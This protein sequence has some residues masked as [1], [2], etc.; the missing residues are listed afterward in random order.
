MANKLKLSDEELAFINNTLASAPYHPHR[1]ATLYA[2]EVLE[3]Q[4]FD[5]LLGGLGMVNK[6]RSERSAEVQDA[7]SVKFGGEMLWNRF[8]EQIRDA[9]CG[10]SDTYKEERAKLQSN[11]ES[12]LI[13]LVPIILAVVHI[14]PEAIGVAIVL[15]LM[16]LKIGLKTFCA[17]A[18]DLK[19]LRGKPGEVCLSTGRYMNLREGRTE[20]VAEGARFPDA[21]SKS[22]WVF[23]EGIKDT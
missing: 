20:T 11:T 4:G 2:I 13:V 6:L 15:S 7:V 14:P 23:Y 22:E 12:A 17:T 16:I 9:I 3:S 21:S 8:R 1:S 10:D 5:S 19:K 18:G